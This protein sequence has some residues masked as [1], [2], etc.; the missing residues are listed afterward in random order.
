MTDL[1]RRYRQSQSLSDFRGAEIFE[2][3]QEDDDP[4]FFRQPSDRSAQ[5]NAGL[6]PLAFD[7]RRVAMIGDRESIQRWKVERQKA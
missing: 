3:P 6:A 2:I 4:I 1:H 5:S 7:Q